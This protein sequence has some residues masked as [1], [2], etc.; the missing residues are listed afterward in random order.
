[1]A[2]KIKTS[3]PLTVK[4]SQINLNP[5]NPKRHTDEA[6]KRQARNIKSVGLLGGIVWNKRTGNLVDGHRRVYALDAINGYPDKVQDYELRVEVVELSEGE[7]KKQLA[8]MAVGNTKPDLDMLAQNFGD[9][10]EKDF[11]EVGLSSSEIDE[12][13]A[14]NNVDLDLPDFSDFIRQ[15]VEDTDPEDEPVQPQDDADRKQHVKEVRQ[16]TAERAESRAQ[17]EDAY[18]MLSF[19]DAEAKAAFCELVGCNMWDKVVKGED[20]LKHIQ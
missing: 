14:I 11:M 3:E 13:L 2:T 6:I 5:L 8:Y 15:T 10:G 16:Q 20:V 1:M 12:I 4:R 17:Y 18:I 7:E 19:S 9:F